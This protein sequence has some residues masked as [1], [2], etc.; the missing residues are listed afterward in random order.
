M[1]A[2]KEITAAIQVEATKE[3]ATTIQVEATKGA[4]AVSKI[5]AAKRAT[6]PDSG[7]GSE[8]DSS[9]HPSGSS[10]GGT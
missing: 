4:T 2:A 8:G 3:A 7:G 6:P 1:G 9:N 10:R 5:E